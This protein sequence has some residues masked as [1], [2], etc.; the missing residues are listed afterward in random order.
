MATA[1]S[2]NQSPYSRYACELP[3]ID[4]SLVSILHMA[5]NEECIRVS[6]K[7][8]VFWKSSPARNTLL[9]ARFFK[10]LNIQAIFLPPYL[11][12][13]L[14]AEVTRKLIDKHFIIS[15]QSQVSGHH[16][17]SHTY[18]M[19][20]KIQQAEHHKDW[21]SSY[22][23]THILFTEK[24][25]HFVCLK[26][27]PSQPPVIFFDLPFSTW[28]FI[29]KN[30]LIA[31]CFIQRF[32]SHIPSFNLNFE[33][34]AI[35][36]SSV[37]DMHQNALKIGNEQTQLSCL[38]TLV[39][40]TKETEGKKAFL[41]AGGIKFLSYIIKDGIENKKYAP[42]CKTM[43]YISM[44]IDVIE[45][46]YSPSDLNTTRVVGNFLSTLFAS[47]LIL[48]RQ[49]TINPQAEELEAL[50]MN[51]LQFLDALPEEFY[52]R[53]SAVIDPSI[54]HRSSMSIEDSEHKKEPS[55]TPPPVQ[56]PNTKPST[57]CC[58]IS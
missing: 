25:G 48:Q 51:A 3:I 56:Q 19:L 35:C 57:A 50:T 43:Q 54:S 5:S 52:T 16:T 55:A 15:T 21:V 6:K 2:Q 10:K 53:S 12:I 42:V 24:M 11:K 58:H 44:L 28:L 31:N 13:K 49:Y 41:A 4:T 14:T 37:F 46:P 34:K 20:Q 7:I 8:S 26:G 17:L 23:L 27:P 40:L 22:L 18:D 29:L 1:I 45:F 47:W 33:G 30:P 9:Q 36:A 39:D 32:K 38:A